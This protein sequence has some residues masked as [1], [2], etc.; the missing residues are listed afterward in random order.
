MSKCKFLFRGVKY[1]ERTTACHLHSSNN[2]QNGIY[3]ILEQAWWNAAQ[4]N[5]FTYYGTSSATNGASFLRPTN[6]NVAPSSATQILILHTFPVNISRFSSHGFWRRKAPINA[7]INKQWLDNIFSRG[8]FTKYEEVFIYMD[9]TILYTLV[10]IIQT[11]NL[12]F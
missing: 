4:P 11:K 9:G 10:V 3:L 2:A 6:W 7:S 5:L 12:F 1:N 8:F